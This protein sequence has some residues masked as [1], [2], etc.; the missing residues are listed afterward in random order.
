MAVNFKVI[1]TASTDDFR[2]AA[3]FKTFFGSVDVFGSKMRVFGSPDLIDLTSS[4]TG[5]V[6]RFMTKHLDDTYATYEATDGSGLL[7]CL[8]LPGQA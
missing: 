7:V 6:V 1:A 3:A 2:W 5:K 8:S 4:R